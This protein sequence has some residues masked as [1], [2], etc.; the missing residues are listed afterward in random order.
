MSVQ[1]ML[2]GEITTPVEKRVCCS[3]KEEYATSKRSFQ[4]K[5]KYRSRKNDINHKWS[6]FNTQAARRGLEQKLTIDQ[7]STLV[8]LSCTYCGYRSQG[9]S[10]T[11][12]GVDRIDSSQREYTLTNC[13][14]CCSKC[15][16]MK[17]NLEHHDFLTQVRAIAKWR[18]GIR[19]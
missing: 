6:C 18:T 3:N 16:F 2:S 13:V 9:Y 4:Q 5:Y 8:A 15:N 14:P 12:I 19:F 10:T 11:L 7:Y 17:G 1:R